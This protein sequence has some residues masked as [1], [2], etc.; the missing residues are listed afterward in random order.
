[1]NLGDERIEPF[2][3]VASLLAEVVCV[4]GFFGLASGFGLDA[5]RQQWSTD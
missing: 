5:I 1:M 3:A 2:F 4:G